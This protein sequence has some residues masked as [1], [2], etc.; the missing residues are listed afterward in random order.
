M[1]SSLFVKVD[2][3]WEEAAEHGVSASPCSGPSAAHF[4]Q[5]AS[6]HL[7]WTAHL[8]SESK[9]QVGCSWLP[10]P[11]SCRPRHWPGERPL[12]TYPSTPPAHSEAPTHLCHT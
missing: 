2:C 10:A 5:S 11:G 9:V 3:R 6:K 8:G 1:M 7:P 12:P 4:Q